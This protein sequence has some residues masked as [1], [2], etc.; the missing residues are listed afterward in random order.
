M[1]SA[2]ADEPFFSLLQDQALNWFDECVKVS[3]KENKSHNVTSYKISSQFFRIGKISSGEAKIYI[4]IV[5][6]C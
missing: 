6:Y 3:L 2:E 4:I 1:I 5:D